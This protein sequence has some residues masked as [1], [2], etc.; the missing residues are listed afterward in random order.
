MGDRILD[1]LIPQVGDIAQGL[2]GLRVLLLCLGIVEIGVDLKIGTLLGR[3]GFFQEI[4]FFFFF[5]Y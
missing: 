4:F 2:E 3:G 1:A 5:L